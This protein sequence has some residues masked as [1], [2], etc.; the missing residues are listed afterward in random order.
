[1]SET[2]LLWFPAH[3]SRAILGACL[4]FLA[5]VLT[6]ACGSE[7]PPTSPETDRAALVSLY[8]ATGGPNWIRNSNW[9]T[10]EPLRRWAGVATDADGRVVALELFQNNLGGFIPTDVGNLDKLVALDIANRHEEPE[11]VGGIISVSVEVVATLLAGPPPEHNKLVGCVPRRLKGQLDKKR[12]YLGGLSY[13]DKRGEA[14]MNRLALESA[15]ENKNV[16]AVRRLLGDGSSDLE[17]SSEDDALHALA[18]Q[19]GA[20]EITEA[21]LE[22]GIHPACARETDPTLLHQA[23]SVGNAD[24]VGTLAGACPQETFFQGD[25]LH[26]LAVQQ[27]APEIT[28]TLLDAG[29]HP[30]CARE[31]DPTLL[32]QAVSVGN[33]DMVGAL[34]EACPQDLN[35]VRESRSH[36][37]QTP[38]SLAIE[39]GNEDVA[40]VLIAAGA[41]PN[42]SVSPD[43]GVGSHLAYAIDLGEVDMVR[44]LLKVGADVNVVDAGGT[45]LRRAFDEGNASLVRVLADAGADI[46]GEGGEMLF[47]AIR[48]GDADMVAA[49]VD[50][51]V[52]MNATDTE[53]DPLLRE[54]IWRGH[55]DV[56]RILADAGADVNATDADGNPLLRR[57]IWRGHADM[58][59]VLIDSGVDVNAT[60]AEGGAMLLDAIRY[61]DADMVAA[62][63]DAGADVNAVDSSGRSMLAWARLYGRGEAIRILVAAG[64]QE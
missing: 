54:A 32:H 10:D 6:T 64:A 61:G 34:A 24:M 45:P 56:V 16:A 39:S 5:L 50:A 29:I 46:G 2:P 59:R 38:L 19:Q 11:G 40:R 8:H 33:A 47:D 44:L 37:E 62:L 28:E 55:G 9:L 42:V 53:G 14:Q 23:V 57:A 4:I 31:T 60:D 43:Y 35:V 48:Y 41:D 13:C 18:V 1:M 51:G 36:D 3:G 58:V 22:A 30:S 25:K 27:G 20:P 17:V 26:A 49:L 12:S 63:V 21:L 15:I 7:T 52:D